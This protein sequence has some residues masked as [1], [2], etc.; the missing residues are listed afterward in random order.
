MRR[1]LLEASEFLGNKCRHS[2]VREE[3]EIARL[4]LYMNTRVPKCGAHEFINAKQMSESLR[5]SNMCRNRHTACM[6]PKTIEQPSREANVQSYVLRR[7]L[8]YLLPV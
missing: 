2:P 4:R 1:S 5:V 7:T 8:A 3:I 6:S